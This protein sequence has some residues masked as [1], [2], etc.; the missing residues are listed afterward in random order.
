VNYKNYLSGL[1]KKEKKSVDILLQK[2][3][4]EL[5][6]FYFEDNEKMDLSVEKIKGKK[7]LLL[8]NKD[9]FIFMLGFMLRKM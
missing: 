4:S 3:A 5:S 2:R 8:N 6:K 1:S 9:D 7:F